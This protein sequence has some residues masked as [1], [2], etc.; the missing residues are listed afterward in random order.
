MEKPKRIYRFNNEKV[1]FKVETYLYKLDWDKVV[2]VANH[3]QSNPFRIYR[4]SLNQVIRPI[5]SITDLFL[6]NIS[7]GFQNYDDKANDMFITFIEN[8]LNGL[9]SHIDSCKN[10]IKQLGGNEREFLDKIKYYRDFFAKSINLVK[11]NGRFIRVITGVDNKNNF[12]VGYYIEGVTQINEQKICIGPDPT[13]HKL[14]RNKTTAFS[15]NKHLRLILWFLLYI[16]ENLLNSIK[17]IHVSKNTNSKY[18]ET[19]VYNLVKKIIN[20]PQCYFPDEVNIKE[21]E[22]PY[23]AKINGRIDIGNVISENSEHL[24]ALPSLQINLTLS[25]DNEDTFLIPYWNC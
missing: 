11:H 17:S 2:S 1:I 16:S 9:I 12:V 21:N 14:Y 6:S 13:I 5:E 18:S 25:M 3:P 4:Q 22:A 20:I 24:I 19:N 10:I 23:I 8:M 7:H 15:L